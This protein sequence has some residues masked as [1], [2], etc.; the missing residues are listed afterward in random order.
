MPLEQSMGYYR[1]FH[2]MHKQGWNCSH[3][4]LCCIHTY[5]HKHELN[6]KYFTQDKCFICKGICEMKSHYLTQIYIV[7]RQSKMYPWSHSNTV[8]Q[9]RQMHFLSDGQAFLQLESISCIPQS[10]NPSI[11]FPQPF[12]TAL[13]H[14][15]GFMLCNLN[16]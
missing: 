5:L 10:D 12:P 15:F 3:Y 16:F 13:L 11:Y 1:N 9:K 7:R 8:A 14:T 2:R 4:S 6:R